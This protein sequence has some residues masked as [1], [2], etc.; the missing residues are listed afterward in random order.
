MAISEEN[1]TIARHV[2]SVLGGSPQ[3]SK[4]WSDAKDLEVDILSVQDVPVEGV[5]TFVTLGL[6]DQDLG[7]TSD[8]IPL[9]VELILPLAS[10][11]TDAAN[12][13]ASCAFSIKRGEASPTPGAILEGGVELYHP[14]SNLPHALLTHPFLFD[15]KVQEFASKR[16]A[17]LQIIPISERERVVAS[18]KGLDAL[19]DLFEASQIDVFTLARA[20]AI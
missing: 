20:E 16:V 14:E 18:A 1:R 11:Y 8:G 15:V 17:W 19:E 6:S 13:I 10:V 5:S 12:I 9:R 7:I 2:R 4:Y 3:V